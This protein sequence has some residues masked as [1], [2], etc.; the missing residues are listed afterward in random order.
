[1]NPE[2]TQRE[3]ALACL[4]ADVNAR[5]LG[6]PF[7]MHGQMGAGESCTA[8]KTTRAER[9]I[10][11]E[12]KNVPTLWCARDFPDLTISALVKRAVAC[13]EDFRASR[14]A[15][16]LATHPWRFTKH[17]VLITSEVVDTAIGDADY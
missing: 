12:L 6:L 2:L 9:Y 7:Q 11:C 8:K 13:L 10:V 5:E 4:A 17:N 16:T 3:K 1:M 15:A 14:L